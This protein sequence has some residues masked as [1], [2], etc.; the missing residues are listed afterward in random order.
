MLTMAS[1]LDRAR[2]LFSGRPA[3]VDREG[4]FTWGHFVDRVR[5]AASA[6]DALGVNRGERYA[7]LSRNTF[8]HAELIHAG[9][10]SGRIP[11]PVNFRLAAPEIRYILDD[12]RCKVLFVEDVFNELANSAELGPWR[13]RRVAITT[14]ASGAERTY[15]GLLVAAAA[16]PMHGSD[17]D[18]DAILL[19]TGGTT[20]RSKGVRLTHKNIYSNGMQVAPAMRV[21]FD[22]VYL[23]V[24]PMFHSADLLGTAFTLAGGAHAYLPQFSGRALLEAIR[25]YRATM[26]MLAPT[27]L[28]MTLQEPDI[29]SYDLSSFRLIFYGSAPMAVEWIRRTMERF[30]AAEVQQ[31]Y[32]LT[33]TSPI[34]TT[35]DM[36]EHRDALRTGQYDRLKSIGRPLFGVDLRLM[37]DDGREV[38]FGEAGEIVVRGPNV[39]KGY[40]NRPDE[41]ARAFRDGWFHTGDVARMDAEGYIYL[42]DRKKDMIITGGENVYSSEVEAVL[43]QHAKVHECAVIGVPDETYGEALFA[44]IVV[45]PGQILTEEEVISHCRGRIGGYKIPRR[46]AFLPALPKSAMGKILK[47]ELR[48]SYAGKDKSA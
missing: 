1:A 2:R 13:D 12:A 42:L 36:E 48:K 15:E 3:I 9:Y 29:A 6:L 5:R 22:D 19:Y 40:L 31:G 38:P 8:R 25:D 18:D 45:A 30:P 28:I 7:I 27:M 16:A 37:G 47:T 43:Y 41:I 23:H 24:A 11:V 39:T 10:W 32:G 17:E 33:E 34:L 26:A 35:L 4:V 20:G 44:A 14:S 46:L 21:R